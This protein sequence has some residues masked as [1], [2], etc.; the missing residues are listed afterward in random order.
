LIERHGYDYFF[1]SREDAGEI[2]PKD[3]RKLKPEDEKSDCGNFS[4]RTSIV[5]GSGV[6]LESILTIIFRDDHLLSRED[7]R[8]KIEFYIFVVGWTLTDD[9]QRDR[10]REVRVIF[11]FSTEHDPASSS[12]LLRH[13][14]RFSMSCLV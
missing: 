14:T 13:W 7:I 10:V 4:L 2:W 3:G 9:G 8:T 11:V 6:E 1:T 5:M 12:N